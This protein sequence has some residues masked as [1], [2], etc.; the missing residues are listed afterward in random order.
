MRG[1][2]ETVQQVVP[3]L[4]IVEVCGVVDSG[5]VGDSVVDSVVVRGRAGQPGSHD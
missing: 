2:R 4:C 3:Q 5:V 1:K